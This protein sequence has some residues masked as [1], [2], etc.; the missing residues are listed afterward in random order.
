MKCF[1]LEQFVFGDGGRIKPV[2][3]GLHLLLQILLKSPDGRCR[4]G[5]P[6]FVA[7][8]HFHE[9][10]GRKGQFFVGLEDAFDL[11]NVFQYRIWILQH[12]DGTVDL[13]RLFQ[14]RFLLGFGGLG[15]KI[16]MELPLQLEEL[17]LEF[18]FIYHQGYGQSE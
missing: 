4:I 14:C 9:E 10:I 13:G 18:G 17:L 8:H 1:E 7:L 5:R 2:D 12:F 6:I 15:V 3:D 11:Q 16:G